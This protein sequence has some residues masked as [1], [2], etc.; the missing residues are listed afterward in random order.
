MDTY[1]QFL[2]TID[3]LIFTC[4]TYSKGLQC[5]TLLIIEINTF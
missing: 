2:Q 5:L 3:S 1:M 4:F